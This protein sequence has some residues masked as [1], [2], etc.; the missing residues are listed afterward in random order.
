MNQKKILVIGSL[1]I[2]WIIQLS[3]TPVSGETI[4]GEFTKEVTGGKGANQAY[5]VGHL[6][7]DV[8]M[9]GCVGDDPQGQKLI[10]TLQHVGVDTRSISTLKDVKS[11]LALIYVNAS[12]DNTIV[13]LP[14][15]NAHVTP[16][17]ISPYLNLISSHDIIIL[18]M[19]IPHPTVYN[20]IEHAH[21]LGKTIIL[22]PAPACA[23]IPDDILAKVDYLTP[24]ETE[25]GILSGHPTDT[26][27]AIHVAGQKVLSKGTKN[28]IVTLGSQGAL[29]LNTNQSKHFAGYPAKAVDTTAAGDSFNGALAVY[30]AQHHTIDEAIQFANQVASIAVTREGAQTSIPSLSEVKGLYNI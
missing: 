18:Q 6:G 15:A 10:D 3:H 27:D 22:N 23:T 4:L 13:V 2:D 8:T 7:G 25:L 24:N 12:G 1:N 20:I 19:E 16:D 11:G 14:N 30:L 28:I 21:T 9:V 26:L 5:A 29:L 17:L